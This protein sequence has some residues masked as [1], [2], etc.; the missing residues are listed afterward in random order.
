MKK[1]ILNV[2]GIITLFLICI[3]QGEVRATNENLRDD[4]HIFM[5]SAIYNGEGTINISSAVGG[6]YNLYYQGIMTTKS[7]LDNLAL[8]A[9]EANKYQTE[10]E[11]MLKEEKTKLQK[12]EDD[13]DEVVEDD[14][15]TEE[16][17]QQAIENY[18]AAVEA[19]NKKLEDYNREWEK[20]NNEF[21]AMIPPFNENKWIQTNDGKVKIDTTQNSGK[22]YF[23]LWAKLT[24]G[25][26]TYYNVKGYSSD[27]KVE[28]TI[29]LDK[30]KATLEMGKTLTLKATTV[31][32]GN[33]N[34]SSNNTSVATVDANGVVTPIKE[35]VATITA[36]IDEKSASCVVTVTK[37]NTEPEITEGDF[38][39]VTYSVTA[40][41]YD[42]FEVELGNFKPI[43]NATYYIYISKNK[44]EQPTSSENAKLIALYQGKY[45]V[46]FVGESAQKILEEKGT[47]YIYLIQRKDGKEE[48][49]ASNIEM[50]YPTLPGLGNRMDLFLQEGNET[51]FVNKIGISA[52]R[53]ITYKIGKVNSNDVL[54]AFKNES[55]SVAFSKLLQYAKTAQYIKTGSMKSAD[56]TYNIASNLQLEQNAYYFVYVIAESEEGKYYELEDIGIYQPN[57]ANS[58]LVHFAYSTIKIN[59]EVLP[60]IL[61][62]TGLSN[63]MI[64]VIVTIAIVGI[65]AFVRY[66]SYRDIK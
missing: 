9:E 53:K 24:S 50:K 63:A 54:K 18:N 17:K 64:M 2:I 35:G 1:R 4:E 26:N 16:E 49:V 20:K 66:R 12:L 21:E 38:S 15:K 58:P 31:A 61:P 3:L 11:K 40:K 10:Q 22:M 44:N 62:Q 48:I 13:T 60:S 8:K 33:I 45:V 42:K 30:E 52:N 36:T 5:P 19:F 7:V 6:N 57:G 51:T 65:I 29:T 27:V 43:Q 46:N 28:T 32:T 14:T 23:I 25:G 41:G 39:K 34:W 55:E 37:A 56:L 47:D 59:E